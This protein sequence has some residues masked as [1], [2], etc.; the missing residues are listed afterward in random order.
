MRRGPKPTCCTVPARYRRTRSNNRQNPGKPAG[1]PDTSDHR[2]GPEPAL[3]P[4]PP[5]WSTSPKPEIASEPPLWINV[6]RHGPV[7]V[8]ADDDDQQLERRQK[9][10]RF[11]ADPA[12]RAFS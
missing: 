6:A 3:P 10:R 5:R 9:V 4:K 1:R 11:A 12:K 2:A 7:G 8:A